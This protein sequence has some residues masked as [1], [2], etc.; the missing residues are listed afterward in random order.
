[1]AQV[2]SLAPR[3]HMLQDSQKKT[4]QKNPPRK[5]CSGGGGQLLLPSDLFLVLVSYVIVPCYLQEPGLM[6]V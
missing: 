1:M 6:P 4:K 2:S 3:L 5:P